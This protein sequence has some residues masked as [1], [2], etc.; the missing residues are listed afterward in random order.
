MRMFEVIIRSE[1]M[2]KRG[3]VEESKYWTPVDI[4]K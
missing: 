1:E 4:H 3:Q 2:E